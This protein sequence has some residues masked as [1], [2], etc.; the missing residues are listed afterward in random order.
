[1]PVARLSPG[2]TF[3]KP[4]KRRW[5]NSRWQCHPIYQNIFWISQKL[6]SFLVPFKASVLKV[7]HDSK[8]DQRSET[9]V[10]PCATR[11]YPDPYGD[12]FRSH[13]PRKPRRSLRID[14][15]QIR[16]SQFA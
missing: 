15:E 9:I 13:T 5:I 10:R 14:I 6:I 7:S 8:N 11:T 12:F 4:V 1:M 2:L 3:D 16:K